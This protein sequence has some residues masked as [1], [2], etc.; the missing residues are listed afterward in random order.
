MQRMRAREAL[1]LQPRW[2][3]E[4]ISQ[5]GAEGRATASVV[6]GLAK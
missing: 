3:P 6:A 1:H 2:Q 4:A 5:A